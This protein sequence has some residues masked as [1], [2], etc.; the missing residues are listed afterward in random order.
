M[1]RTGR[2]LPWPS[3]WRQ[4]K[5]LPVSWDC[6]T[7]AGWLSSILSI[8]KPRAQDPVVQCNW[9]PTCS[10]TG[11]NIPILPLANLAWCRLPAKGWSLVVHIE[12]QEVCP[13]CNGTGKVCCQHFGHRCHWK[14]SGLYHAKHVEAQTDV[15]GTS[16][17]QGLPAK[18]VSMPSNANGTLN[19]LPGSPST[20]T[21]PITCCSMFSEMPMG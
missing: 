5:K 21:M 15:D 14:G 10:M 18:E 11:P 1:K 8:W 6:A 16:H 13:T 7:W 12:T 17:H 19:I 20:K 9:K 3:T 4:Q 2:C